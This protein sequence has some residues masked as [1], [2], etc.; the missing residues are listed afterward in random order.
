MCTWTIW[1]ALLATGTAWAQ[2]APPSYEL[3]RSVDS[4]PVVAT[5]STVAISFPVDVGGAPWMQLVFSRVDLPGGAILRVTSPRDGHVHQLDARS[6]AQWHNRSAYMNGDSLVVEVLADPG[7]GPLRVVLE[8]VV[9]G[10]PPPQATTCGSTDDRVLSD[11]PRV[12]R[13]LPSGCTGWLIDDCNNGFLSA[14]HCYSADAT[15][16]MFHTPLSTG[17]GTAQMSAPENQYPIDRESMQFQNSGVGSDWWYFGCFANSNTGLTPYQREG[18]AFV[19]QDVTSLEAGATLRVTGHGSDSTPP[20]WNF[21]Q[22]T[23]TGPWTGLG[24]GSID[25]QADT[26]GGNSGSPIIREST[27]VAIGVHTHGGCGPTSGSNHGTRIG[28]ASLQQALANPLGVLDCGGSWS[29]YCTAKVNSQGCTPVVAASANPSF[30]G[31]PGSCVVTASNVLNNQN[32]IFFYGTT[33]GA[34]PFQGGTRCVAG[35][36]VRTAV[37]NAGGNPPPADC[38]GAYTFDL[39]AR[40]ASGV[41]PRLV[42][43]ATIVGQFWSRDPSSPSYPS[44]LTG[45]IRLTIGP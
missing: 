38:S 45:G 7:V 37:Q 15:T 11:D 16:A 32:G 34:I 42:R 44:G 35:A 21:V 9:V 33:P 36:I 14:G 40:I 8:Q 13:L 5:D 1:T 28:Q 23:S 18:A 43:G 2:E 24:S 26:Q 20:T 25:H 31:G 27:G 22:Q 4:G 10:L 30:S 39:G 41:D 19:L 17:G 12:A 3:R 6:A 29:T